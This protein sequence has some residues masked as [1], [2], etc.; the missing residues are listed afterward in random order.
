MVKIQIHKVNRAE[1]V[2]LVMR[3]MTQV[4]LCDLS[5]DSRLVRDFVDA[6]FILRL[7]RDKVFNLH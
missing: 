1:N 3:G 4:R 5:I 7:V 6:P 2:I